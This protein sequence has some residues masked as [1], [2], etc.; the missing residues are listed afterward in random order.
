MTSL[1]LRTASVAQAAAGCLP[2]THGALASVVPSPPHV[3]LTGSRAAARPR[4]AGSRGSSVLDQPI[5]GTP[6]WT[7][8]KP[9]YMSSAPFT[10]IVGAGD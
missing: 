1:H 5:S 9:S 6:R 10:W 7:L 2:F 4:R 8:D 3:S